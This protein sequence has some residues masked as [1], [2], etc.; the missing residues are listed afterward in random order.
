[1]AWQARLASPIS[2]SND[3][4]YALFEFYDDSDAVTVLA[5]SA[6]S[7]PAAW[8]NSDMQKAV[9]ARGAQLRTAYTRA[10]ALAAT[11]PPA[12]TII[13]IP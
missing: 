4:V 10:A 6:F 8:T 3:S 1:M 5:T 7:F 12:T 11:F 2:A 13:A 9:Q